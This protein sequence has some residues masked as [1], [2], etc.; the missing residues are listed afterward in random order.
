[1]VTDL[2]LTHLP[3]VF[4]TRLYTQ[5]DGILNVASPFCSIKMPLFLKTE[6]KNLNVKDRG[7]FFNLSLI[8]FK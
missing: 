1:M 6:F 3:N 2:P 7:L 8:R 4:E 5:N